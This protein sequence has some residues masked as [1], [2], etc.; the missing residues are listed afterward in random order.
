MHSQLQDYVQRI[1]RSS[2]LSKYEQEDLQKE[3]IAHMRDAER[4][5]L[6]NNPGV[7]HDLLAQDII[8]EFGDPQELAKQFH[9]VHRRF[10]RLPFIGP[11]LYYLPFIGAIRVCIVACISILA[12]ITAFMVP[13]LISG[14]YLYNVEENG[15]YLPIAF[16]IPAIL[17]GLWISIQARK[18]SLYAESLIAGYLILMFIPVMY[19]VL[20]LLQGYSI[21]TQLWKFFLIVLGIHSGS[22]LIARCIHR[23]IVFIHKRYEKRKTS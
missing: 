7:S 10:E 21:D 3:L 13:A 11:F 15:W 9:M 5:A 22:M 14:S 23:T 16:F 18:W 17:G 2:T 1:I 19:T 20:R 4:D 6:L 8:E 12:T